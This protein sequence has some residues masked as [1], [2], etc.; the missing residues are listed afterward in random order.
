MI[1]ATP[2]C[3]FFESVDPGGQHEA[4]QGMFETCEYVSMATNDL[5]TNRA[6]HSTYIA[7]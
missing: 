7:N 6:S 5:R 4:A 2:G 3:V 1:F